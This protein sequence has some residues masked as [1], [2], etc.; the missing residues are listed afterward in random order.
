[1]RAM[2]MSG[3]QA[4]PSVLTADLQFALSYQSAYPGSLLQAP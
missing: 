1:M 2:F 4:A 3:L